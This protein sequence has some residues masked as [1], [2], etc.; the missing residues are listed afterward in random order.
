MTR[1]LRLLKVNRELLVFGVFLLVAIAFW[2]IQ[3]FKER[4]TTTMDFQLRLT[5]VPKNV[6]ITSKLPD[7]V[8]V[9]VSGRGFDIIDYMTKSTSQVLELDYSTL[10]KENGVILVDNAVWRRLVAN[11]LGRSITLNSITPSILEIYY[12]TGD[13]RY[14]PVRF[15]GK[16][17]V[18]G[19]HVLCGVELNPTYVDVYAP[20]ALLDTI[21]AIRTEAVVLSQLKDTMQLRMAL[22]PPKGVKCV[23]DTI[24]ATV[25]VDLFSSKT[26][27]VPIYSENIPQNQILRT[28]PLAAEVSFRVSSALYNEIQPSDFVLVVDYNLIKPGERQCSLVLRS[29]PDG[30]SNVKISPEKVDF[31]IEEE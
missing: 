2:F 29:V 15:A 1:S 8:S 3:S 31:L 5:G 24:D 26:L 23:P 11:K 21:T 20:A 6:I 7:K 10:T 12:S 14:V 19:Q 13:R 30:V 28:F 18:D 17:G 27:S 22:A 25:C 9:N 4:T 16:V